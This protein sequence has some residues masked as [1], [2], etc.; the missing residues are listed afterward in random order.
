[1]IIET[2]FEQNTDAWFDAKAGVPSSSHYDEIVTTKGEPSKSAEAYMHKLAGEHIVGIDQDG[3]MSWDMKRGLEM[4]PKAERFFEYTH[5]VKLEHPAM[6]YLDERK[7][8]LCSPDGL[9]PEIGLEIKCPKMHTHVGYLM[10]GV[11]PYKYFQQVHGSMYITGYSH[12]WFMSFYP[13]LPPFEIKVRRNEKFISALAKELDKFI[14]ELVKT[15]RRL[16]EAE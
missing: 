5:D 14:D 3:Y 4:Q 12:W 2:G 11:L 7:D 8:R 13:D 15:I 16:K 10:A 6:C 1:M 9:M